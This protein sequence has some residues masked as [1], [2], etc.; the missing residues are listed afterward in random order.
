MRDRNG[1]Q[2]AET[3]ALNALGFLADSPDKLERLMAQSG[4]DLATVRERAGERDFLAAVLDF[5]MANEDLLVDF[6]HTTGTAPK[7]VHLACHKLGGA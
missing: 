2:S 5:L 1:L 3:M 6:C 4:V 7:A